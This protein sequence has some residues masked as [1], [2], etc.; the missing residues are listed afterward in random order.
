MLNSL[1]LTTREKLH[2]SENCIPPHQ[3][4]KDPVQWHKEPS[5]CMKLACVKNTAGNGES[6]EH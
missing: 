1:L 4:I 5:G 2:D 3:N 6:G